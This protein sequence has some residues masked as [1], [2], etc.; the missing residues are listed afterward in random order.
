MGIVKLVNKLL[1][2]NTYSS[3]AYVKYIQ[4]SG[5]VIGKN[6]Y[7]YEPKSVNIDLFRPWLLSIGD[8]VVICAKTTILTHDY[9]HTVLC[10]KYGQN[11]GDAK[12]VTIGNNVFIG[13]GTLIV[14][15][16]EIGNNVIIGAQSVVHGKIPDD[17]V[18]AGNPA[19]VICTI[20][21]FYEKRLL[22]EEACAVQNVQLAINRIGR[23][24]T[25]EE[26]GDAFAWMYMPRDESTLQRY[27][28]FFNLPG[29][30]QSKF[31][32]DFME[33]NQKYKSYEEFISSL[34]L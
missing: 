18:V 16:T 26:M 34:N 1:Y 7:I 13:I 3:D 32:K 29:N 25:I 23:K 15:G 4:K 33:S 14:M 8:N 12:P 28:Q 22:N 6:C 24:P 21:E 17:C 31:K 9:S 19:K 27:P 2:P 30:D 10:T 20:E 11:I 5:G